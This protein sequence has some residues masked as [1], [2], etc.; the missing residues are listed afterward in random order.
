MPQVL[1]HSTNEVTDH[2]SRRITFTYSCL[3]LHRP[4]VHT[5]CMPCMQRSHPGSK[6]DNARLGVLIN[7]HSEGATLTVGTI[8]LI[9]SALCLLRG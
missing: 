4:L 1:P 9:N 7:L 6:P 3:R 5:S 2:S 8:E